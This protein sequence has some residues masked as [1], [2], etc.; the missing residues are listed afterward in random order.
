MHQDFRLKQ[1]K[2]ISPVHYTFYEL[3]FC[4]AALGKTIVVIEHNCI[5]YCGY[6]MFQTVNI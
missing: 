4:Y 1:S 5:F 2:T 6:I 3:D